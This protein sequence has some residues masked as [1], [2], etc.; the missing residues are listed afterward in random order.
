[1]VSENLMP[2]LRYKF[3][4]AFVGSIHFQCV[5]ECVLNR[6]RLDQPGG[7]VIACTHLSHLEPAIVSCHTRR[8]IT[9]IAH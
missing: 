2:G 5:K 3:A 8:H 4:R 1:M 6:E 9:W 7:F